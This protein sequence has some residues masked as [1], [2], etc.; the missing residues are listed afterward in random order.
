MTP[1]A[2][3]TSTKVDLKQIECVA[4]TIRGLAMDAT[5]TANSGHPGLPL[6]I[7]ESA[8]V[9]WLHFL[10]YSPKNPAWPD[11]DRFVLSAG[12]GST[13]LYSLLHL[14]GYNLPIDEIRAFRQWGSMTPGHPEYGHTP[15]VETTTGPLGQGFGNGVGMALAAQML[16]A[17]FNTPDQKLVDHWIYGLVSDGDLMEGIAAEAASFAGHHALGRVI[18]LYDDNRISIEGSTDL[19]FSREDVAKRFEAYGWH[20]QK[21]DNADPQSVADAIAAAQAVPDKPHLICIR[22]IIGHPSPKANTPDVHGSPLSEEEI[23]ETKKRMGWPVDVKFHIPDEAREA[24]EGRRRRN[25][26]AE[27]HWNA[28]LAKVR[29]ADPAKAAL[30]DAHQSLALPDPAKLAEI[31]PTFSPADKPLA[32]RA[33]SGKA[34]NALAPAL[35]WLVGGSA[36]LAPSNNTWIKGSD[37]IAAG[38]YAGRNIHFG[39]REHAMG[40]IMNGMILHGGFRP[41]GGTFLVFADYMRPAIRLAALMRLPAIYVLT[42][43]SI[44]LGE[45]GP[46]HQPVETLASL[47][48]IPG[49]LVLRPADANETARAWA[50][51]LRHDGPVVLALSRQGLPT[52]DRAAKNL[53]PV[54]EVDRGG[55]ILSDDPAGAPELILLATGSEVPLCL[56]AAEELRKAG[57][58]VRVVNLASWELFAKQSADYRD[59]V[60]PPACRKRLAVEAGVSFG[61][62][63]W[64]GEKGR[65]VGL[66][67]FG[68]SAPD[69]VLAEKFGFTQ[70]NVVAVAQ[71]ML[72]A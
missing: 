16:E 58:R 72:N 24:F 57:R 39:I 56:G 1:P 3:S 37:A 14:A 46:T 41:F 28:L 34:I 23:V 19:T 11:R 48:S 33:A 7:A 71:E 43:D 68:A 61:W 44:F 36:D 66:D 32:S 60:L 62:H 40:S 69:K 70:R 30:W 65:V 29:A 25:E 13:L 47:R 35:P 55:Y 2:P 26:S 20:V 45:D 50:I 64:V 21:A 59:K 42:H 51:A 5:R 63:R 49:L 27:R 18:Y 12:H 9:L 6:G 10:K 67:H 54:A 52:L 22:S 17:R 38:K 53:A 31:L 4:N 8:A 15:G